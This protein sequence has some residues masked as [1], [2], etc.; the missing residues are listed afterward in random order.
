MGQIRLLSGLPRCEICMFAE[1]LFSTPCTDHNKAFKHDEYYQLVMHRPEARA[2]ANAPNR[3][4]PTRLRPSGRVHNRSVYGRRWVP[5]AQA[6]FVGDLPL[7]VVEDE[8]REVLS[9]YGRI[10]CVDILRKDVE[11]GK[12]CILTTTITANFV[13]RYRREGFCLRRF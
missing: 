9:T 5:D 3:N 11:N 13:F 4:S 10:Q 12:R 2:P 8:I 7:D 6:V 1:V